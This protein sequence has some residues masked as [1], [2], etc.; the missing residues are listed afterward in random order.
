MKTF[1]E[2]S[3]DPVK[4]KSLY[5]SRQLT[6]PKDLIKWCEA[7]MDCT[8]LEETDFHVTVMYSKD[9]VDWNKFDPLKDEIKI[10]V[11]AKPEKLGD[12][13]AVVL[14]FKSEELHDRWK[15]FRQGGAS[16]DYPGYQPHV[17]VT[18][19]YTGSEKDLKKI[20]AFEGTFKF[21]PEI[22]KEV[23]EDWTDKIKE[24]DEMEKD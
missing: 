10:K 1:K 5:V 6:N 3:N 14:K 20:K 2:F 11:K 24:V 23:D 9:S 12:K 21:G 22:F 4:M 7:N 15:E 17:T 19:S 16:W 8:H 13:G 18:Y